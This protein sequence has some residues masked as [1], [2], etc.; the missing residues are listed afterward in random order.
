MSS[1]LSTPLYS[2]GTPPQFGVHPLSPVEMH[3]HAVR[4]LQKA[5]STISCFILSCWTCHCQRALFSQSTLNS[6]PVDRL[7]FILSSSPPAAPLLLFSLP[8]HLFFSFL[9]PRGLSTPQAS[10]TD[11]GDGRVHPCQLLPRPTS[12]LQASRIYSAQ[13][14][15]PL[16]LL[17]SFGAYRLC[18][19]TYPF[20]RQLLLC[21]FPL[22]AAT[23]TPAL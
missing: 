15:P 17:L 1:L 23:P 19:R 4:N 8:F 10:V 3:L 12:E 20:V 13:P 5:Q 14:L 16:W 22:R 11:R 7:Q 18:C 21:P 2:T 9:F 6:G